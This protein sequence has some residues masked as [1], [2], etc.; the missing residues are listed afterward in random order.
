M[1]HL[2]WRIKN[3]LSI[4]FSFSL[5]QLF[6]NKT[7]PYLSQYHKV[8]ISI[9]HK[10]LFVFGMSREGGVLKLQKDADIITI[11]KTYKFIYPLSFSL[12]FLKYFINL[13]ISQYLKRF[14][15]TF[16]KRIRIFNNNNNNII[17]FIIISPLL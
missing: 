6:N 12:R 4:S 9:F 17:K 3:K 1:N 8:F 5:E 10:K 11:F 2:V 13:F 14:H 7:I 16:R 15:Q